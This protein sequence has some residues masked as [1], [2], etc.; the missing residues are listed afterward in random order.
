MLS[1]G[2]LPLRCYCNIQERLAMDQEGL[3][4]LAAVDTF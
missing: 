1:S 3:Y 4:Y 2:G